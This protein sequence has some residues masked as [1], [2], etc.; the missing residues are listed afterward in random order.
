MEEY[1]KLLKTHDWQFEYS[2]DQNT[3]RRGLDERRRMW[4]LQAQVDPDGILWNTYAPAG[5]RYV[6]TPA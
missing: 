6:Q 4:V 5:L 1:L 2:S 3:W